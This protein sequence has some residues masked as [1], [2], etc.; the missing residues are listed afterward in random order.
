MEKI[1]LPTIEEQE[2]GQ[3]HSRFSI[4]PLY[5]GYGSTI[6]NALRRVLLSSM[7]GSSATFFRVEGI[8][9]EFSAIPG[10][11]ED[12]VQ[13]LMNIKSINFRSYSDEPVTLE[14]SKKGAGKVTA[15][16]FKPNSQV[17]ISNPD[18]HIVALDKDANLHL[19]VIVEKD[20]GFRPTGTSADKKEI[21]WIGIDASF[22]P[23]DRVS[24]SIEDTRVGQMTNFDKLTLDVITNGTIDPRSALK[25]ASKVLVDHFEAIIS[26]PAFNPELT[27]KPSEQE[28]EVSLPEESDIDKE[29]SVTDNKIKIEDA[30]FSPRTANAL[31]NAGVKTIAGLK[32]LSPL[33]IEE[34][35]G[36]GKKGIAE[37]KEVLSRYE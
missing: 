22:S 12:M 30:G 8:N 15:A 11:K 26:D 35:K 34:I 7:T 4:E 18:Q 23:V 25:E 28:I 32:R 9:H 10:V 36:L 21:G 33:K 1:G 2:I 19:E 17:E 29:E 27:I 31:V 16:D 20:R 6:G 14:I 5:P 3:N 13:L 24:F 37:V